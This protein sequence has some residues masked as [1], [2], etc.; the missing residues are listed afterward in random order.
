[1]S[2]L[3]RL[4]NHRNAQSPDM[5]NEKPFFSKKSADKKVA[6]NSFFQAKLAVNEPDDS[7]EKEADAVADAVVN[8]SSKKQI[9]QQN[10]ISSVQRLATAPEEEKVSSN[11]ERMERDKEKPFQ[12]QRKV[13]GEE[14]MKEDETKK[15]STSVQAK[16][17]SNSSAAS[18]QVS[19]RIESSAGKGKKLPAKTLHEMNTSFGADFSNVNIHNDSE[20]A[21]MN[22]E[23]QAHA[24]TH[25]NDIYFN[26]GKFSPENSTG[27]FLLAHELTHVIQQDA[28]KNKLATA[29][30]KKM[31]Q[32]DDDNSQMNMA[33]SCSGWEGD[34]QSFSIRAAQNFCMD[35][36]NA[37]VS[38][39]DSIICSGNVCTVHYLNGPFTFN[40]TVDMSQVPGIVFVSGTPAIGFLSKTCSY[41]YSC[42]DS[43]SIS[44]QRKFC[45]LT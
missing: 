43:G 44:F 17:E 37:P 10:T 13:A 4:F 7:F 21:E 15:K 12:L 33:Q 1:M 38:T 18:S 34:P 22:K 45:R 11:D 36:F 25:G 16:H 23:L 29:S 39:P 9:A 20:S 28:N 42:D 2:Y 30:A 19:S 35:A 24:F 41:S 32:K 26:S 3:S 27:K 8:K 5:K 6:K 31:I 40:I 14:K